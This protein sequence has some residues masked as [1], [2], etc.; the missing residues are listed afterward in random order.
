MSDNDKEKDNVVQLFPN[1][2]PDTVPTLLGELINKAFDDMSDAQKQELSTY[3]S[4]KLELR[5]SLSDD[6]DRFNLQPVHTETISI[7]D[8]D[9]D[10]EKIADAMFKSEDMKAKNFQYIKAIE[11]AMFEAYQGFDLE[12]LTNIHEDLQKI[13]LK[14]DKKG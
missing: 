9:V 14:L 11:W 8:I 10:A 1:K 5:F 3:M 12:T 6:M 7:N 4:D 13:F 2:T